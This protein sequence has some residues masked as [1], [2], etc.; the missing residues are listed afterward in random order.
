M[1]TRPQRVTRSAKP[2]SVSLSSQCATITSD[3]DNDNDAGTEIIDHRYFS[4]HHAVVALNHRRDYL[5]PGAVTDD[6]VRQQV[7]AIW[8]KVRNAGESYER[9]FDCFHHARTLPVL[10]R[11]IYTVRVDSRPHTHELAR[12]L[13]F[14]TLTAR[15]LDME[16]FQTDWPSRLR[17]MRPMDVVF[18]P[19]RQRRCDV[20]KHATP[21]N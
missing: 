7:A 11:Q 19:F 13:K 12:A 8:Q 17:D 4:L 6:T 3:N 1:S 14:L 20:D 15:I 9:C 10:R 18:D 21:A 16:V 5:D 2:P